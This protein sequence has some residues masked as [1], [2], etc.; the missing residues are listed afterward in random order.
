MSL[1][2]AETAICRLKAKETVMV[3]IAEADG[4][5]WAAMRVMKPTM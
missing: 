5:D 4:V 3:L 2:D 1:G